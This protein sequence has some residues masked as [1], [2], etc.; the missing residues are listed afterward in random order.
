MISYSCD[1]HI[2]LYVQ[3]VKESVSYHCRSF[4]LPTFSHLIMSLQQKWKLYNTLTL[5]LDIQKYKYLNIFTKA[6]CINRMT[7]HSQTICSRSF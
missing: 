3:A 6:F 1:L 4:I 7:S 5:H 2:R